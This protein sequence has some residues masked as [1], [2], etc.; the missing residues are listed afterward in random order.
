MP[1]A[2]M[3]AKVTIELIIRPS[4]SAI[5]KGFVSYFTAKLDEWRT[6]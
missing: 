3:A 2:V 6:V 4:R 1:S 5:F